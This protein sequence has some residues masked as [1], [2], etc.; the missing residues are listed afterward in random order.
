[1]LWWY[2]DKTKV[3]TSNTLYVMS[4]MQGAH[5]YLVGRVFTKHDYTCSDLEANV[6]LLTGDQ[7]L[8]SQWHLP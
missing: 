8:I 5:S 2:D 3:I 1:M 6:G 7:M 4:T